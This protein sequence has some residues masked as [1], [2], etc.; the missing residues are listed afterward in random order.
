[1]KRVIVTRDAKR[2]LDEIWL[3]VACD[4]VDAANRLIDE[5][6]HRFFLIGSSPEM[7]RTRSG[8]AEGMKRKRAAA[9]LSLHMPAN[10]IDIG[11]MTAVPRTQHRARRVRIRSRRD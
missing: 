3:F 5:I 7:G 1:M 10:H 9:G 11:S 6:A 2:D 4:S 8:S